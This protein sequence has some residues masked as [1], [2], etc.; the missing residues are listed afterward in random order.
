MTS[1]SS[2]SGNSTPQ[3]DLSSI[4]KEQAALLAELNRRRRTNLLSG[5]KPYSKQ[6][7]FHAAGN[8]YRE[9]L[10]MAGNQLGKTLAGAAEAAMHL[11]GKYP[12][13]WEG[14]RYDKPIVAIAGSESYELTRDGVQRLLVGPPMTEEEWGT[15][16]IPKADIIS[17]TRRSGVSGALDSI[18][19]R[20]VSGGTSTL[21]FKAY[22][23]GRGKWQANTVDYI[24]F[25]EEPP[26]DVYFEGITRTNATQGLIAVTFTPLKGMSSVV[27]RYILEHSPDRSVIT[28]TIEDAEHH[29]PEERQKII[30]SYPAHEREARTKGVPSLGSGR[31][32]PVAEEL[33]TVVPFEVPKH[34][35]QICGIDFGWDH[36][37]AGA[38]LAWDRDADV[39][40]VTTV[41]R[42]REAT[43][44]VHAGAL[45][46]WGAWLPWSW[47]H[48]GNND[49]AAGPNLASQYRAQGLN[50]LPE[51]ATFEDGSNSV[52][53]GLME[54]LDRMITGRFKV[55]STCGEWFEEFRL[56]HR[57]DGKVVK[58]RDDVIS[59]SR[60]ALMMKRFAKVKA[61]AAAWKF[62]DRKVV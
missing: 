42:Q 55:F 54:M 60:Y 58:E 5:Y 30:D 2:A 18:T 15:G 25:D 46:P 48:D 13:W 12:D 38:R 14:K 28:M 17:S 1:L 41:Y 35:V 29:T 51:R 21:L 52:E 44:I 61:D 47:P 57:K 19:V 56:Y 20:H 11:T 10:F 24:W 53:A 37:T 40:Y 39:I 6:K 3:S 23:Q 22:E 32:F 33:I 9:R 50:L 49:M 7:E 16:Y 4:L 43:P 36:P 8:R 34:W 59:A 45:K 27:A 26:E 62:H 31:I